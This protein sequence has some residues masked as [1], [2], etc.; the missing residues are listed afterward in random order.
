MF[1]VDLFTLIANRYE[2]SYTETKGIDIHEFFV[3][4][5]NLEKKKKQ[6]EK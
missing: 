3:M 5:S 6:K 1:W 4:V 2:M